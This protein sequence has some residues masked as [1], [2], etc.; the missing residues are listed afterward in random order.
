ML[1]THIV[2]DGCSDILMDAPMSG[3]TPIIEGEL[4]YKELYEKSSVSRRIK[5]TSW[6]RLFFPCPDD[7]IAICS[8]E[9]CPWCFE[10]VK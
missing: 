8:E 9:Y 3:G 5:D 1:E 10:E 2:C 6:Y 7:E 4:P